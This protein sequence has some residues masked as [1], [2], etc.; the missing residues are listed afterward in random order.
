MNIHPLKNMIDEVESV[1]EKHKFTLCNEPRLELKHWKVSNPSVPCLYALLKHHKPVDEDGD[2]KGR[3]V[4][5]NVNAPTEIIAKKLSAIFNSLTPP[6][7]KAVK[8]GIEFANIING[9]KI[10]RN[11]EIGSYDVTSL[12]PSTP[13]PFSMKLLKKWLEKNNVKKELVEA[14]ADLTTL[15]MKQN[16]F[17][18]RDDFYNQTELFMSHFETAMSKNPNFP[19]IYHRYVDDIFFVQNKRKIESVKTLFEEKLDLIEKD[20]IKFTIERQHD[21]KLPF[22]NT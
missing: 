18:F 3:P 4:A 10:G 13:I 9:T 14:Y 1:L 20:A 17:Q 21:Q 6:E 2:C 5:S 19:R 12:Y 22:L 11:E 15:C 8:N 16:I 7:G